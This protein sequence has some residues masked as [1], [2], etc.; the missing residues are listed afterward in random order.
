MD[1]P[2][3]VRTRTDFEERCFECVRVLRPDIEHHARSAA[4]A[5]LT[6][7]EE[8]LVRAPLLRVP[9]SILLGAADRPGIQFHLVCW[10]RAN[11][12]VEGVDEPYWPPT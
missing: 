7:D 2:D 4:G 10:N 3:Q 12:L 6:L 1:D 5:E 8:D 11:C 9:P